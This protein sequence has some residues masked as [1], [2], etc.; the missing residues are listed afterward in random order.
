MCVQYYIQI[1]YQVL[2]P[3]MSIVF[4]K[5]YIF[6]ALEPSIDCPIL[7]LLTFFCILKWPFQILILR[8]LQNRCRG[9]GG[10]HNFKRKHFVETISYQK[11]EPHLSHHTAID[12]VIIIYLS[13]SRQSL[14]TVINLIC[15][16]IDRTELLCVRYVHVHPLNDQMYSQIIL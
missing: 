2:Y 3:A 9:G 7:L 8:W 6:I 1:I 13:V 12:S 5:T 14:I 11:S 4:I 15:I 10:S 16:Y